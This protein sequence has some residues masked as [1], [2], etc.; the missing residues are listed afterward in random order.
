MRCTQWLRV[1][2]DL[3][4]EARER[5]AGEH[6]DNLVQCQLLAHDD[7]DHHGFLA[8]LDEYAT[9]LWLRWHGEAK[10][11]LVALTDCPLTG[12]GPDAEGCCLFAGHAG[13]HTWE[14]A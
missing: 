1:R 10:V 8:E 7:S 4:R 13:Q 11:K 3:V 5:S 2:L 9:A 12:P 14:A 6:V